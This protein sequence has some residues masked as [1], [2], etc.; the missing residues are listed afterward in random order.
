[1]NILEYHDEEEEED[2][3]SV[4]STF[5][6][7]FFLTSTEEKITERDRMICH[8]SKQQQGQS[9]FF[10]LV[11]HCLLSHSDIHNIYISPLLI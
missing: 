7:F 6:T 1:V 9:E 4:F 5:L 11:E 8:N 3:D 2:F 10:M